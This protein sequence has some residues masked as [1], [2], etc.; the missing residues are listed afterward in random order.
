MLQSVHDCRGKLTRTSMGLSAKVSSNTRNMKSLVYFSDKCN[1]LLI[2]CIYKMINC[3]D[4]KSSYVIVLGGSVDLLGL[5]PGVSCSCV[6]VEI[7]CLMMVTL[8]KIGALMQ[9]NSSVLYKHLQL[10]GERECR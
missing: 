10:D 2:K 5:F 3:F 4:D 7:K 1:M 6:P 8:L 9:F